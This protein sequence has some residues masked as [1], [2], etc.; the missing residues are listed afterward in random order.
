VRS[1]SSRTSAYTGHVCAILRNIAARVRARLR[2]GGLTAGLDPRSFQPVMPDGFTKERILD[3]FYSVKYDGLHYPELRAYA[4][5]DCERFLHTLALVPEGEG[6]LLEI[7]ANPYFTTLLLRRFRPRYALET[8]NYIGEPAGIGRQHVAFDGFDRTPEAFDVV[9]HSVNIE[10]WKQPFEDASMDIV[11]FGEVLEHLTNDPLFALR[12]IARILKIGGALVL[13]TPNVAR[14][15]NV[16]ALIQGRNMYDPFSGYGP[17]G[18]H[19]REYTRDE[20]HRLLAHCGFE[21]EVSY[22]ANVHAD[23]P[24]GDFDWP[25]L[26]AAIGRIAHRERDLGQ[27]LFTRWRKVAEP[28]SQRPAWLY[29][30][31]PAQEMV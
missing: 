1:L 5:G 7:G 8:T 25:A 20:L 31:Y 9:Y 15:E 21:A 23:H 22:T 24:V 19:N 11:V 10:A 27:Y 17:Y 26:Q 16:V 18:R 3:A 13:T 30:S 6:R 28:K 4:D 14:L 2:G 29:R 12:E